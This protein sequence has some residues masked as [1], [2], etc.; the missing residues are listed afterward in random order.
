M[1]LNL[2]N[3]YLNYLSSEGKSDKTIAKYKP[4]L[5]EM[6][7]YMNFKS[8]DDIENTNFIDLK[9]NW[10][11]I[12]QNEGLGIQS[13]NLRIAACKGFMKYLSGRRII[14]TN[15][16]Q[17]LNN[18]TVET[19]LNI[20][21]MDRIQSIR[22]FVKTKYENEPTFLNLRNYLII[23]VLLVTALRNEELR[24]LNID[25]INKNDGSFSV[26]G[27]RGIKKEGYLNKEVLRIYNKYLI[28]RSLI[29]AKDNAL[30]L[31][32]NKRRL[33]SKGLEDI[34][35]NICK[36]MNIPHM[37]VHDLR[38]ISA[39]AMI[40]SGIPY[41][42]VSKILGHTSKETLYKF[43]LHVSDD[44]KKQAVENNKIFA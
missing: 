37:R 28:D 39:T 12:K 11:K 19:K 18:Y 16:A 21:N 29:N 27:K 10:I 34:V 13:L 22:N 8:I 15:V 42:V 20:P 24:S 40:E 17:D 30:F 14:S 43:Y 41:E 3:E 5:T 6:I 9:T 25:S 36:E 1:M 23:N 35:T 4:C 38:H 2:I 26:I 7:E 33:S 31:S 44:S 32:K